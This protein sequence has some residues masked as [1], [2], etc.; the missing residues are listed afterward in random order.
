MHMHHFS[1]YTTASCNSLH[2]ACFWQEMDAVCVRISP[3]WATVAT[4]R[5]R[6]SAVEQQQPSPPR[7]PFPAWLLCFAP[8]LMHEPRSKTTCGTAPADRST[9][10]E[11]GCTTA[12]NESQPD[13]LPA[14][15]RMNAG[16]AARVCKHIQ[17]KVV[18][19]DH[20]SPPT[21]RRCATATTYTVHA[22]CA[23]VAAMTQTDPRLVDRCTKKQVMR[24]S[25][26][27]A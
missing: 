3:P 24:D 20:G 16:S 13:G 4:S 9:S 23:A 18:H 5:H 1:T 21:C 8:A 22:A 25:H 27:Y 15:M 17:R 7:P 11:A 19:L 10:A 14:Q 12:M 6:C 26:T 2:S